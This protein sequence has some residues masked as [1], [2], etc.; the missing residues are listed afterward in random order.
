MSSA[1]RIMKNYVVFGLLHIHVSSV[2]TFTVKAAQLK[3]MDFSIYV[4]MSSASDEV[5]EKW[6][7]WQ[8]KQ[9]GS[10]F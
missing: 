6:N 7:V 10:L 9:I 1:N 2:V 5:D 8:I 4:V 3:V